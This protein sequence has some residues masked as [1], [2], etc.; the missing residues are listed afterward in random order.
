MC[1]SN[2]TQPGK[3]LSGRSRNSVAEAKVSTP[4]LRA[5]TKREIA[6]RNEASSSTKQSVGRAD[7]SMRRRFINRLKVARRGQKVMQERVES[8]SGGRG[9]TSGHWTFAS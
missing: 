6:D 1:S 3:S 8:R 7:R 5:R 9:A 2:R 4:K